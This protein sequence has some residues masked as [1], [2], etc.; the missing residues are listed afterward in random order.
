M[1]PQVR[2][3][4]SHEDWTQEDL[5]EKLQDEGWNVG[6]AR[7]AKIEAGITWVSALECMFLAKVFGIT[8]PDLLPKLNGQPIYSIVSKIVGKR[9][10]LLALP[11]DIWAAKSAKLLDDR[12]FCP[13]LRTKFRN[14]KRKVHH[15]GF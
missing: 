12:K 7:I 2:R 11:E 13:R 14:G 6:R 1:G 10:K 9:V 5:A 4:R 15:D 8:V 3:F